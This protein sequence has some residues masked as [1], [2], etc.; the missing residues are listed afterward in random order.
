[1]TPAPVGVLDGVQVP[2]GG[3]GGADHDQGFRVSSGAGSSRPL[4][5]L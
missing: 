1:V 5:F 3:E 2:A 4:P